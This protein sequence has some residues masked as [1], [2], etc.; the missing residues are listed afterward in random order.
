[1]GCME[2][3]E[4]ALA[5][6]VEVHNLTDRFI[7]SGGR[8]ELFFFYTCTIYGVVCGG[9]RADIGR[10]AALKFVCGAET[11]FQLDAVIGVSLSS[12]ERCCNPNLVK[13]THLFKVNF[14]S[15]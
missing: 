3:L 10:K 6:A 15:F 5:P 7:R 11:G 14:P 1:M 12:H 4:L 13:I 9:E 2:V 8:V